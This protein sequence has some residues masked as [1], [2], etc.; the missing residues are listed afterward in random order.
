V[1]LICGFTHDEYQGLGGPPPPGVDLDA[2]AG[3]LRL[4]DGAAY[5]R[6][7][8]DS[9]DA[10]LFTVLL[11]DALMRMPT[12]WTAEAH[13]RRGGRTWM[14]DFAW[15]SPEAGHGV[16]IP[17]VFGNGDSRYAARFLGSPPHP[18]FGP[19]SELMR[20]AWTAFA[21]TGDPG[22]PAFDLEHRRTRIWD[23]T[24]SD[25][26]DPIAESR[27]IWEHSEPS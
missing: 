10:D 15:Q 1:D 18:D 22:W 3:S 27:R 5:R 4:G 16:D 7:H 11:S 13:V 14:Y 20:T 2:V 6:A 8:P 12:T 19:L 9:T 25:A 23:T 17:F 26:E 21:A 24:P